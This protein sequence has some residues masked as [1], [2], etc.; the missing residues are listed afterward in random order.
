[1]SSAAT[2][3]GS[4]REAQGRSEG[5]G[6]AERPSRDGV[7]PL[8]FHRHEANDGHAQDA[9]TPRAEQDEA[10][11]CGCLLGRIAGEVKP[12]RGQGRVV[13]HGRPARP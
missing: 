7:K 11:R 12:H 3:S 13:L 2:D 9:A 10:E 8:E 6:G 4:R 1:M 5:G